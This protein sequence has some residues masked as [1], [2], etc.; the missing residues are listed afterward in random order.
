MNHPWLI[1]RGTAIGAQDEK[2]AEPN[3]GEPDIDAWGGSGRG[4]DH[5][6]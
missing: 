5:P 3:A 1:R 4:E 2:F 6:N